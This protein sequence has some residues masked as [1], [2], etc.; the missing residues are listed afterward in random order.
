MPEPEVG[1]RLAKQFLKLAQAAA[2]LYGK[3]E[4]GDEEYD[5]VLRAANDA[6]PVR[7]AKVL[8]AL[9]DGKTT[10]TDISTCTSIPY[11][12]AK[13]EIED[14]A[15]LRV[16]RKDSGDKAWK[17]DADF[18]AKLEDVGLAETFTREVPPIAA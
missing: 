18:A 2:L 10:L 5:L 17:L 13:S 4:P 8:E 11:Q 6:I 15:L 16:V 14:L 3:D 9:F 7:R 12:T 1:T